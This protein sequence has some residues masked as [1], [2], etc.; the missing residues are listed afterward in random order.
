VSFVRTFINYIPERSFVHRLDPATKIIVMFTLSIQALITAEPVSAAA[1]FLIS[2]LFFLA[3]NLPLN[4][5][6]KTLGL[7]I[8]TVVIIWLAYT[9][10]YRGQ[11][12]VL[13][14]YGWISFTD[15]SVLL[16]LTVMFRLFSVVTLAMLLY[17]ST[18][19]RDII[20]GLRKLG[21]P[22]L[23]TFV[24]ALAIRTLSVLYD[25]Y[26]RIREA[27]MARALEMRKG[28]FLER[29]K[30]HVYLM[31]PLIVMALNRVEAMSN[32]IESRAFRIRFGQ[33]TFYYVTHMR[34]TDYFIS[35][36]FILETTIF[37]ILRYAYGYF[38]V[39]WLLSI[40]SHLGGLW[41]PA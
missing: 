17:C 12:S 2:M 13:W 35:I 3:A 39:A 31:A 25:D 11:G 40:I 19:Q 23:V 4:V 30:K 8:G 21:V 28:S 36:F 16:A 18:T 33:R 9:Y 34:I 15:Y 38:T 32:S 29:I 27:Q 7:W 41:I 26:S 6:R 14:Q 20:T 37:M 1:V 22:Y 5:L 10:S 24:F